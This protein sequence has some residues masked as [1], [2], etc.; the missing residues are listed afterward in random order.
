MKI[1]KLNK[2]GK[3]KIYVNLALAKKNGP[4][5]ETDWPLTIACHMKSLKNLFFRLVLGLFDCFSNDC[6]YMNY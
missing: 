4:S 1:K 5:V 3:V 6:L 2:L